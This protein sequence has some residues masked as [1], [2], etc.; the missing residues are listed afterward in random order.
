MS[1]SIKWK[2]LPSLES[3]LVPLG[4]LTTLPNNPKKGD[5]EAVAESYKLFGQRKTI[6]VRQTPDGNIVLA[7][8]TQYK[9]ARDL[10]GWPHIAVAWANDDDDQMAVAYALAD[11]RTA[12]LGTY[13]NELLLDAI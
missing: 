6:V 10:L 12:D 9:A 1:D 7:G 11:N 13:D 3:L 2:G 4:D 8:N 5:V